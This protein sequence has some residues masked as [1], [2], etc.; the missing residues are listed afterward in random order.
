MLVGLA[1]VALLTGEWWL[2]RNRTALAIA[3]AG[4]AALGAS[5]L[6]A[7]RLT[8]TTLLPSRPAGGL[9]ALASGGVAVALGG[10]LLRRAAAR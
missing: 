4:V 3:A 10:M 6:L 2:R 9:L 5:P 1:A 7:W 8:A